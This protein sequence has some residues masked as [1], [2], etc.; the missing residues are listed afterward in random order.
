MKITKRVALYFF[1]LSLILPAGDFPLWGGED[2]LAKFG[3]NRLYRNIDA[4]DFALPDLKG[5]KRSLSEFRGKF[6]MLNF[7]ATW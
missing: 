1:G 6:I 5:R 3:V 2:I 4:P 7:W